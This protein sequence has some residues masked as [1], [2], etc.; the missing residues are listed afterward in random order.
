M[1]VG[2]Y[3]QSV[4]KKL[5]MGA[6]ILYHR[7]SQVPGNQLAVYTLAGRYKGMSDFGKFL[8]LSGYSLLIVSWPQC[9]QIIC[10]QISTFSV[11]SLTF[12]EVHKNP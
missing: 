10:F 3:L 6:E 4:T 11:N 1:I 5:D 9:T 12:E 7:G 2:Q 8:V